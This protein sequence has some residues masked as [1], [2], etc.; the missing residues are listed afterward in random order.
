MIKDNPLWERA[1]K[2]VRHAL[3]EFLTVPIAVVAAFLM[4]AAGVYFIDAALWSAD[5][6]PP[7]QL[8]WLSDVFGDSDA[9]SSLL[10]TIATSLITVTSI[11]FSLLLIAVQQGAAA[12]TNQ[13]FD[14]FLRRRGNQLYFGFFVGL[15]VFTLAELVVASHAHRP[16]FGA[17]IAVLLTAV[18]L[19]LIVVLIY[20]TI[21]QTRPDTIIEA[22]RGHV[23]KARATQLS[24]LGATR[25]PAS[26]TRRVARLVTSEGRGYVTAISVDRIVRAVADAEDGHDG[27]AEDGHDGSAED[28]HAGSATAGAG[29][30]VRLRVVVGSHLAYHDPL[31]ELKC[32]GHLDDARA[33]GLSKAV[34]AAISLEG[35]RNLDRDP[36]FGIAQ[37]AIIG[38][39]SVSTARSNPNPGALVCHA[40][41]DIL[42]RWL[43]QGAPPENHAS[44]I[45]YEDRVPEAAI[46]T[47]ESLAVVASESMQHQTLAE[48]MRTLATLLPAL[49]SE[50]V[51]QVA[52]LVL[53]SLSALGEHVLTR[54]LES[55]L[56]VLSEALTAVGR[57]EVACAV[58]K[59]EATL[60]RSVG[61]LNARSTRV[62]TG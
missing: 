35:E 24:L 62:P 15:S 13:E 45:V 11:I 12:L 48:V 18:A 39:T 54:D 40:L 61:I 36:A 3:G 29:I 1:A 46:A 27:S 55:A 47:L 6:N 21:D 57:D 33:E 9:L 49:P 56:E 23:L 10:S 26:E 59:A 20:T 31:A 58:R 38:W 17:L 25:R 4:L 37:L 41:R 28:G 53:R 22:I 16:I 60:R 5:K 52:D 7:G 43:E 50:R 42:A 51:N 19:C 30:E 2:S 44:P 8:R 34:V 14:Q 32:G